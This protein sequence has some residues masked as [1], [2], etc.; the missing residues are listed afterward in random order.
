[1]Q[2]LHCLY[3]PPLPQA[4]HSAWYVK[5]KYLCEPNYITWYV[6][7]PAAVSNPCDNHCTGQW[8]MLWSG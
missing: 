3:K 7:Y 5:F 8:W 1:M 6:C 4:V 2:E